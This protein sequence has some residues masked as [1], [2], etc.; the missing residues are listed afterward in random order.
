[1]LSLTDM[2]CEAVVD[3]LRQ[4]GLTV[5]LLNNNRHVLVSY[6]DKAA[7]FYP[8]T[9]RWHLKSDPNPRSFDSG[10][11]KLIRVLKGEEHDNPQV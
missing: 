7:S 3:L 1:M 5:K 6:G 11:R 8:R 10:T 9:Q 4:K 2:R